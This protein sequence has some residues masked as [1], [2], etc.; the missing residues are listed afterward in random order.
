MRRQIK[1]L[2]VVLVFALSA[3]SGLAA[4]RLVPGEYQTIQAAI[5]ATEDGDTVIIGAGT[6]RGEVDGR[7]V[8]V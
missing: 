5:V 1:V 8:M 2:F 7:D 4:Y 3:S 6:Y